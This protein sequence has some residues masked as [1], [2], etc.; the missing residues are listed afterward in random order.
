MVSVLL[1][2]DLVGL[3]VV[4]IDMIGVF[5]INRLFRI[6]ILVDMVALMVVMIITMLQ[7]ARLNS[8]YEDHYGILKQNLQIVQDLGMFRKTYFAENFVSKN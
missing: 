6:Q 4:V 3:V 1:L 8:H 5:T 7:G 2:I